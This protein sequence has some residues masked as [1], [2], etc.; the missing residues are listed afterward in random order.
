MA[1]FNDEGSVRVTTPG[2]KEGDGRVLGAEHILVAVGGTPRPLGVPG[3]EHVMDSDGFFT[4]ESQPK[5]VAVLGAGYIA[6]ELAGVLNG[7]GTDTSL[8]V[9][10]HCALREFDDMISSHLDSAMKKS[11]ECVR[12]GFKCC[13]V[14]KSGLLI[15]DLQGSVYTPGLS[16]REWSRRR[17]AP[18]RC[19]CRTER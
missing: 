16:Q 10:R 8:F 11:G 19:T 14:K 3:E 7:L 1:E 6:V 5:K 15:S 12:S 2:E 13:V 17:M 9:R 18:S 4:L